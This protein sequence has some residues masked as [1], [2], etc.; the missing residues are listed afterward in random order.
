MLEM[1]WM[2]DL[3]I[4]SRQGCLPN[5]ILNEGWNPWVS[6]KGESQK[7]WVLIAFL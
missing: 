7:E 1:K 2:I 6:I 4:P 5:R 3:M